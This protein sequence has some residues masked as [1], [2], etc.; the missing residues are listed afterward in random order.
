MKSQL[1]EKINADTQQAAIKEINRL[2][3]EIVE[4]DQTSLEKAIEAG[5]MLC[6]LKRIVGHGKWTEYLKANFPTI[7]ER[8]AQDYM[9]AAKKSD[10]IDK[11]KKQSA[12][13]GAKPNPQRAALLTS[14]RGAKEALGKKSGTT[15][16][17]GKGK[18]GANES[19]KPTASP[20]S[21]PIDEQLEGLDVDEV[22]PALMEKWDHDQH[23]AL[24]EKLVRAM[25]VEEVAD[26]LTDI[27]EGEDLEKL[28]KALEGE[29]V[30]GA[31]SDAP[32]NPQRTA[33]RSIERRA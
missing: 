28:I 29:E 18:R 17:T 31:E 9:W 6:A 23:I 15:S 20:A 30:E 10:E 14:I 19:N 12:E 2:H 26:T 21:V 24:V 22:V 11:E 16:G 32:T 27:F 7:S 8:T 33:E 25:T 5:A 1:L 13:E 3:N 4:A